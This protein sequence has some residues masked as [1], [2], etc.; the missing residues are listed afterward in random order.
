M[1]TR[2]KTANGSAG[3]TGKRGRTRRKI[4]ET[5]MSLFEERGYGE[6]TVAD[7]S[8]A[9]EIARATFFL[10]FP[11]KSALLLELSRALA[12]EWAEHCIGVAEFPIVETLRKLQAFII[13]RDV[14]PQVASPLLDEFR[15]DYGEDHALLTAPDTML[16]EVIRL[17]TEGQRRREMNRDI[18]ARELAL[19]F[20]RITSAYVLDAKGS[21]KQ[22]TKRAWLLFAHGVIERLPQ[23][24]P[25]H[26][27]RAVGQS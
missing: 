11:T 14:A 23:G 1:T 5:A 18:P 26:P 6:T 20:H 4:L 13:S 27:R 10:H 16:G 25:K 2:I 24:P 21:I 22:R 3:A 19:H 7:I 9:A 17:V 8:A 12:A 15:R